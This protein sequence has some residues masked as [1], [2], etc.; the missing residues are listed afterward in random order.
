VLLNK[1]NAQTFASSLGFFPVYQDLVSGVAT[2]TT[3]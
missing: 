3:R 2:P 1:K